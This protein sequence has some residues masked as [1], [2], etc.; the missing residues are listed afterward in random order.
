MSCGS[1]ARL[2]QLWVQQNPNAGENPNVGE[3]L[4]IKWFG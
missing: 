2:F 4:T 3:L 1:L